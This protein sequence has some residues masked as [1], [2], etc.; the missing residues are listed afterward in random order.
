LYDLKTSLSRLKSTYR[1]P[2]F[3]RPAAIV[4]SESTLCC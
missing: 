4:D 2:F 1:C 3:R